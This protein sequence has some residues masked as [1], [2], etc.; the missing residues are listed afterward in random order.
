MVDLVGNAG[1]VNVAA[2]PS[3]LVPGDHYVLNK[4]CNQLLPYMISG[5]RLRRQWIV[6]I[7]SFYGYTGDMSAALA[8]LGIGTPIAALLSPKAADG[9]NALDV[10]R[11]TL[12][13]QWFVVGLVALLIW[14]G[15][16]LFVQK[17][18]VLARALLARECAQSMRTLRQNLWV[19]LNESDPMPAI[20][21][22]QKSVEDQV[23]NAIR[24]KAWPASWDPLPPAEL[25][26]KELQSAVNEIR[27]RFMN[28]WAP[29]PGPG[30]R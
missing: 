7:A 16:R 12:P 22:I 24:N 14:A 19:A 17:E 2:V 20:T 8:G 27:T 13:Q 4:L 18:D 1:A 15:L 23:Q 30:A 9:R 11:E 25:I 5:R 26:A 6:R 28:N 3:P 10:L 21:K 29:P